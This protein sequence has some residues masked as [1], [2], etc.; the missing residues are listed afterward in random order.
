MRNGLWEL[1][2]YSITLLFHVRR[3]R[4]GEGQELPYSLL[5]RMCQWLINGDNSDF[6]LLSLH[7]LE[8]SMLPHVSFIPDRSCFSLV[9]TF[10]RD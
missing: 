4:P 7:P 6:L 1:L 2:I 9:D 5:P 3:L 8:Y 10:V